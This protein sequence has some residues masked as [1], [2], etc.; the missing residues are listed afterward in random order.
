MVKQADVYM[1]NG[2]YQQRNMMNQN[3]RNELKSIAEKL[4]GNISELFTSNSIGRTSRKI[5]IE[6][7][8]KEKNDRN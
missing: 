2:L 6:Y 4:D 5:V 7:D 1:L 8:I 3:L